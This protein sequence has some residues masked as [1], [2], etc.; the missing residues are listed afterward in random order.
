MTLGLPLWYWGIVL[1]CVGLTLGSFGN[2]LIVRLPQGKDAGGRSACPA[3]GRIL[4]MWELI[5]VVSYALLLGRC[6]GCRK[7]ISPQY[8]L[9]EIAAMILF[10]GA[11][12][13][14]HSLLHALAVGCALWALLLIAVVDA[15]TAMIPDLFLI[16]FVLASLA[17]GLLL[18]GRIDMIAP[19]L[20]AAF[21]FVQWALSRGRWIGS[22]DI[23]LGLGIGL[24]LGDWKLLII[25]FFAA[26]IVGA[27][28]AGALLLLGKVQRSSHIPFGPFLAAGTL[29]ALFWGEEIVRWLMV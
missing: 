23:W 2:V 13:H 26:Y 19:L 21:F 9:V 11:L 14:T 28:V 18:R 1:A 17:A 24:L 22:G 15:R 12:L 7:T 5:P 6:H 3:C 16:F 29:V 4:T 10:V 8:P 27:I 20:G 25:A